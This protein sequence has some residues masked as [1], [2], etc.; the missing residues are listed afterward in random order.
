MDPA[1]RTPLLKLLEWRY[2]YR[3]GD[4][5]RDPTTGQWIAQPREEKKE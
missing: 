5:D 1:L 3:D 4:F 2:G